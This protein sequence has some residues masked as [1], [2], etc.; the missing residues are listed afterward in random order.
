LLGDLKT[1]E[2]GVATARIYDGPL[3]DATKKFQSR[4]GLAA[5]GTLDEATYQA[6]AT[7]IA[8][9]V[10]QLKRTLERWR[11]LPSTITPAIV[12]NLPEYELRAFDENKQMALRMRVIVGKAYPRRTPVFEDTLESVIV[13]PPWNAPLSIQ[14]SEMVRRFAKILYISASTIWSSSIRRISRSLRVQIKGY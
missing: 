7:P 11:W 8:S 6:L 9:R 2:P 3:F 14:R 13:R 12:V 10:E 1:A 4:H 5:T